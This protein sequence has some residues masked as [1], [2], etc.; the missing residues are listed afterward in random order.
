MG[1]LRK[2]MEEAI[3]DTAWKII[4]GYYWPYRVHESG[5]VER[6]LASGRWRPVKPYM[7]IKPGESCGKL[8]IHM[9][10][11]DGRYKN[12]AVKNLVIDTFLG[13]RKPG[14]VYMHRN[15]MTSDCSVHNLFK[16]TEAEVGKRCGGG[17]KRSIEKIDR[18]GN[19]IDLY[20]SVTEAAKQNFIPRRSIWLRCTNKIKGDPFELTGFSYRYER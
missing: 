13:G 10:L 6:L 18:D 7:C 1:R 4:E 9:R 14:D 16:T 3:D 19:V 17:T 11:P 8:M 12:V 20:S 2:E 15:R 5:A